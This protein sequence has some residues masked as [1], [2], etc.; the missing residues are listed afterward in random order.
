MKQVSPELLEYLHPASGK[1]RKEFFMCDLYEI[2]LKSGLVFR[3]ASYD[4]DIKISDVIYSHKGPH[5]KRDR[6]RLSSG[7]A[8]DKMTVR[9]YVDDKDKIGETPMMHIAHN[10]GFDETNLSLL[11]CFMSAP[12]V[13]V[14]A[15]EMFSGYVDV[16][17]AGGLEMKWVVKSGVQKLNVDFPLRKYYP[18]CPHAL[19]DNA[20]GLNIETFTVI[21]TVT[22]VESYQVFN[23]DLTAV[24][25]Y[26][27]QGGIEWL[28]GPL[29]G[30]SV[31]V[32]S[33]YQTNG[34]IIMLLPLDAMPEAGD[35][36]KIYP[37]CDKTPATCLN[38]FN[39]F[40]NNRATP[41]IP[42]KETIL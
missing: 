16:E 14:G 36:F 41:Y 1:P 8:V 22:G 11:R 17:K 35:T 18:T 6:I 40:N 31:P 30:V 25:G 26:Y 24:D 3:Y 21:G 9:V 39:N 32:K 28:S 38:K 10:G 4:T 29:A 20:C 23:T 2:T 34:Q 7:I 19:Y 12:G 27:E 15:V 13:V 5:F 33:S 37:G 42:L